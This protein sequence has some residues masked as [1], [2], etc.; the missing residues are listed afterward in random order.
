MSSVSAT[1]S[2]VMIATRVAAHATAAGY[3]R[4]Q[5][6]VAGA[7]IRPPQN[8]SLPQRA[9]VRSL[10]FLTDRSG[11]LWYHR[12]NLWSE[13]VAATR[14]LTGSGRVF[15]FLYGENSYRYLGNLG[16]LNRRNSIVCTYHTPEKR[17]AEVVVDRKHLS[18]IDAAIAVSTV[19]LD[20]LARL[21]GPGRVHFIPHGIDVEYFKPGDEPSGETEVLDC[22]FVGSHLRDV[23]TLA[24][25]A[26]MLE[27]DARF[28]FTLVTGPENA[29]K[30]AGLR[31]VSIKL[32]VGDAEL[33]DLY[34]RS[35]LLVFPLI[36]CTA[37]NSLLEAMACG[38]PILSTDLPG[39]RDYVSPECAVL[40]PKGAADEL[41]DKLLA[42]ESDR[43]K[44]RAMRAASRRRAL[45]L[46]WEAVA[47]VTRRVYK[48]VSP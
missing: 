14:W 22:L 45:D 9:V 15:H 25:V 26:R 46:R 37:N 29:A 10:Q 19:Q 34:R 16:S 3:D 18:R 47:E 36:D 35:H 12:Q 13:L 44:L 24:K 21:V 20:F 27:S 43:G 40:V 28:R 33:L 23:D 31:N 32:K 39:V 5:D 42:L 41:R 4:L 8:W 11:S 48:G 2:V 17:F 6:Y 30:V 1:P 7:V 38:L